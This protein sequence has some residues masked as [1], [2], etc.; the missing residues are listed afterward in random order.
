MRWKFR[1]LL[2]IGATVTNN[3]VE[4]VAAIE[5]DF[6][7]VDRLS[8]FHCCS[9]WHIAQLRKPGIIA[10]AAL[11]YP[12]A[13]RLSGENRMFWASPQQA[14]QFLGIPLRTA[15]R[16]WEHLRKLGFFVLLKSGKTSGE[17]S[18]F[19]V[20][21]HREWAAEHPG[22]CTEKFDCGWKETEDPLAIK[23]HAIAGG[24]V[25]FLP[26]QIIRYRKSGLSEAEILTLFK[27][28]F[29]VHQYN[30]EQ[31]SGNK[32][33]DWRKHVGYEFGQ[34]LATI[35][36]VLV[37]HPDQKNMVI[38]NAIAGIPLLHGLSPELAISSCR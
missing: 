35:S 19:K 2:P 11:I 20:L 7:D 29:D 12:W 28:W 38:E 3:N 13:L 27:P 33:R 26:F 31:N 34:Y 1:L 30:R 32:K 21:S 14:A 5:A 6:G 9:E 17:A 18:L 8:E 24:K 25:K 23:L 15:Q 22:M 10:A 4:T 16:G 37:K 36:T